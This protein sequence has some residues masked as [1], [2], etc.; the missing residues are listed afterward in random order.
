MQEYL[1]SILN[2][3]LD[4]LESNSGSILLV[5]KNSREIIVRVARNRREYSILGKRMRFGEGISGLVAEQKRPLLVEDVSKEKFIKN[6]C[7]QMDYRTNS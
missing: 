6:R 7:R 2:Q 5:S 4:I 1:E 3:C